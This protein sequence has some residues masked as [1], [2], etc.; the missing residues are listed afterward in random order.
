MQ[1]S[2]QWRFQHWHPLDTCESANSCRF[3]ALVRFM[4]C[5]LLEKYE[6]RVVGSSRACGAYENLK[7]AKV[8]KRESIKEAQLCPL[9]LWDLWVKERS[10]A[11]RK[12]AMPVNT[13][14]RKPKRKCWGGRSSDKRIEMRLIKDNDLTVA[15]SFHFSIFCIH[16]SRLQQRRTVFRLRPHKAWRKVLSV[17]TL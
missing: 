7:N 3:V 12:S 6:R 9:L 5:S 8:R 17:I 1:S 2:L 10:D 16:D 13:S 15:I 4:P 11:P 14:Q